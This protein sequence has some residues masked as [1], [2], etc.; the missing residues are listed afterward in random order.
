MSTNKTS[1]IKN[2]YNDVLFWAESRMNKKEDYYLTHAESNILR[3]LIHY[4]T[5]NSKI[6]YSDDVISDHTFIAE[7][8]I[9]NVIPSLN[10]KGYINSAV[11]RFKQN[12]VYA[13]RRTIYINWE[14]IE[15]VLKKIITKDISKE[16]ELVED[17]IQE[18]TVETPIITEESKD[19]FLTMLNDDVKELTVEE[20]KAQQK[21][22]N[23][24]NEYS[25]IT[26]TNYNDKTFYVLKELVD[27]FNVV[28]EYSRRIKS[29]KEC[30]S[31]T[32][33]DIELRNQASMHHEEV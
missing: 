17:V 30:Q 19:D 31:Q 25:D 14:F 27:Y 12:G 33:F 2:K 6:T 13:S 16:T 29:L 15:E 9:G 7:S 5:K 24:M 3:K 8:T 23:D 28:Q 1:N 32:I 4:D 11:T 21:P 26:F 20:L 18:P 10:R 22:V